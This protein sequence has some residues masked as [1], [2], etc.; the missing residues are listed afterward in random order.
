MQIHL[1][2]DLKID[3]FSE[4]KIALVFPHMEIQVAKPAASLHKRLKRLM[5]HGSVDLH[6]DESLPELFYLLEQLK[7][8]A[9]LSYTVLNG[10]EPLMTLTPHYNGSFKLQDRKIDPELSL[11]ISRF[12]YLRSQGDPVLESPLL[13]GTVVLKSPDAIQFFYALSKPKSVNLLKE[14]FSHL[15]AKTISD[16]F[17]LLYH[18]HLLS[19]SDSKTSLVCWEF[20]DLLFHTRSRRRNEGLSGGTFR[21]LD[22]MPPVPALKKTA[23]DLI[24]L[25]KPDINVLMQTD[26]PFARVLEER[27]SI[28]EPKKDPITLKQLGEFFYRT[29]RLK[30]MREKGNYEATQRPYPGGG[31]CYELELYPLINK[32]EGVEEGLYRYVP[33]AHA[34]EMHKTSLETRQKLLKMA[35]QAMGKEDLPQ[36]LILIAARFKRVSWKYEAMAYSVILKNTGVLMQ[37]MYLAATAMKLSPCAIGSGDSDLFAKAAKTDYYGETTVG[38]FVLGS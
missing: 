37:T 18:A 4:E 5:G 26:P 30:K 29:A 15:S 33:E 35:T 25:F 10:E 36:V 14:E 1:R 13:E 31:A 20:H 28:R 9:L 21:F 38:E 3:A 23:G 17:S 7:K 24:P 8:S 27:A 11:Q 12:A 32:C 22:K 16:L 6:E 34:F 19:N 2:Q